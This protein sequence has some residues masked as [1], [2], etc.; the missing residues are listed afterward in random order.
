MKHI[1]VLAISLTLYG[2]DDS[3]DGSTSN[4]FSDPF[5]PSISPKPDNINPDPSTVPPHSSM[6]RYTPSPKSNSFVPGKIYARVYNE[7][8]SGLNPNRYLDTCNFPK[9]RIGTQRYFFGTPF[10][11]GSDTRLFATFDNQFVLKIQDNSS[12]DSREMFWREHAAMHQARHTGVVSIIEPTADLSQMSPECEARSFVMK[13][14]LG[15]DLHGYLSTISKAQVLDLGQAALKALE[16]FHDTGVIHGD[17]HLGNIMLGSV[18]DMKSSLTLIDFG[19]SMS[20]FDAQLGVHKLG[21]EM[22][23][24]TPVSVLNWN[25]LSINELEGGPVSRADDLFRLAE[26]LI[27]LCT[28]TIVRYPRTSGPGYVALQKRNRKFDDSEVPQKIQ[29]LYRYAMNLGFDQR[30]NY[31]LLN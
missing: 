22:K 14:V 18:F 25:L 17:I 10:A 12:P 5:A 1:S 28:K 20:Y 21:T 16:K 26:V 27:I 19:R 29:N 2:C 23:P 24:F 15:K 11:T 31:D 3:Q 13:K 6:R 9:F 8:R 30:P 7:K 4:N